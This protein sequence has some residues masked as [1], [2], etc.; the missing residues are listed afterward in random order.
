MKCQ[1]RRYSSFYSNPAVTLP[2]SIY[3]LFSTGHSV[4]TNSYEELR[5]VTCFFFAL[6]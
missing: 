4:I 1:Y 5:R 2:V 6:L 3:N